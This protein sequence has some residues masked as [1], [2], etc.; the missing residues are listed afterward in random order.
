MPMHVPRVHPQIHENPKIRNVYHMYTFFTS[1]LVSTMN[2][3]LWCTGISPLDMSQT[4][5][6]SHRSRF[7]TEVLNALCR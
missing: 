2:T 5:S 4:L 6:A 7:S 1:F 3:S